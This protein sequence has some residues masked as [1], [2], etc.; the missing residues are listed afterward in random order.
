MAPPKRTSQW[1]RGYGNA[2]FV[3]SFGAK[4]AENA[5]IR[6]VARAAVDN[7][8]KAEDFRLK[9]ASL[10]NLHPVVKE[11]TQARIEV[12]NTLIADVARL[13]DDVVQAENLRVLLAQ[14]ILKDQHLAIETDVL[15]VPYDSLISFL[16]EYLERQPQPVTIWK[17]SS[18]DL[19]SIDEEKK[20]MD[21]K[22]NPRGY[23]PRDIFLR[24][25]TVLKERDDLTEE[26]KV[27]RTAGLNNGQ[28]PISVQ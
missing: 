26:M 13:A 28:N 17:P 22:Y 4:L 19:Q 3:A 18:L 15:K 25:R 6:A 21:S 11:R 24:L 1:T 9:V 27:A 23:A 8:T 16:S 20:L 5:T 2:Q 14:S 12:R 10:K 7:V